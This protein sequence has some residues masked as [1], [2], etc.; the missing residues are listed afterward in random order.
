MEKY[1]ISIITICLNA[2]KTIEK[3]INSVISQ[4]YS[5]LEYII[6]DGKSSDNTIGIIK[7]FH[8][9]RIRWVS[10]KD[11]G[12]SDAF[13][14]GINLSTGEFIGL[15]NADDYLVPHAIKSLMNQYDGN[16]DVIYGNTIV[17][18]KE[19]GLK[20]IKK[21]RNPELLKYE[22][23]FIHQ[24][25]LV[26]FSAYKKYGYYST[27][28]KICMDYELFARFYKNGASFQYIDTYV[29]FF[30][31]G[32]TSSLHPFRTA[33]EDI[34]IARI[35]GLSLIDSLQYKFKVYFRNAIKMVLVKLGIWK[36]LYQVFKK[37]N[38]YHEE[39]HI[40]G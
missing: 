7:N 29:S 16:S 3:T 31:Y 10:E 30:S 1:K 28:Y 40:N 37:E 9:P 4:D 21:A 27:D 25:S 15:I 34:S 39:G 23:P 24:S 6:V 17:D 14:K 33:S 12:I 22:M 2:E 5:N 19:N 26:K 13:N 38:L 18:D 20:I 8:D 36:R 32:G 11:N 35:Y